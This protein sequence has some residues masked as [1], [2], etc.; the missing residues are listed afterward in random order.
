M[1]INCLFCLWLLYYG[2]FGHT[3]PCANRGMFVF[4]AMRWVDMLDTGDE[5]GRV[6]DTYHL[7]VGFFDEP[8]RKEK[9]VGGFGKVQYQNCCLPSQA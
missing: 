3:V 9:K 1:M 2:G 4:L 7:Q 8:A 6:A 5:E